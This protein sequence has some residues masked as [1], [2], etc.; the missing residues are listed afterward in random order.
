MTKQ[1][2]KLHKPRPANAGYLL[3]GLN[4]NTMTDTTQIITQLAQL[5]EADAL[6]SLQS[7]QLV[8]ALNGF[9][10]EAKRWLHESIQWPDEM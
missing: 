9:D 4:N 7:K 5:I 3:S 8:S 6:D 10:D 2:L 1:L